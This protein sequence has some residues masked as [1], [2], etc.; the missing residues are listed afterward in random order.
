MPAAEQ[1]ELAFLLPEIEARQADERAQATRRVA[2]VLEEHAA[3]AQA[4]AW[5]TDFVRGTGWRELA[6]FRLP[7]RLHINVKEMH[8]RCA[9][10]FFF[11]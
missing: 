4:Q 10:I 8:A 1:A 3:D 11:F 5:F 9:D 7:P 2:E 6:R